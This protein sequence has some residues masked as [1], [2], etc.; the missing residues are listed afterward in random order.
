[1]TRRVDNFVT[2]NLA[3]PL[4]FVNSLINP[5]SPVTHHATCEFGLIFEIFSTSI[6]R[7]Y[8]SVIVPTSIILSSMAHLCSSISHRPNCLWPM[9]SLVLQINRPPWYRQYL[10]LCFSQLTRNIMANGEDKH[11]IN[12][13]LLQK[14]W[15]DTNGHVAWDPS[16]VSLFFSPKDICLLVLSFI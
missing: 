5:L 2:P 11:A 15:R 13:E 8:Q 12:S 9:Q 1:M 6:N 7:Y 3:I 14:D 16:T 10:Y 4:R